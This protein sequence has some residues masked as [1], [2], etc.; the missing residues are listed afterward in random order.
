M[1]GKKNYQWQD[2][3]EAPGTTERP[4]SRS[5]KKRL[6]L[7]QQQL[8]KRIAGLG[9]SGQAQLDLPDE[10]R[11]ALNDYARISDHEGRRRQLQFIGRLMRSLDTEGLEQ[12]VERLKYR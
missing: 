9:A 4:P 8:G 6:A 11:E 10:L 2:G 7:S 1:G 5:A 3:S 12:A